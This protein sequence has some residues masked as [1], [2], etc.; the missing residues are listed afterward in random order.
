MAVLW[1]VRDLIPTPS[2][3]CYYLTHSCGWESVPAAL[4]LFLLWLHT[5]T[6]SAVTDALCRCTAASLMRVSCSVFSANMCYELSHVLH[7]W[8]FLAPPRSLV[9][10]TLMLTASVCRF[11]D[12]VDPTELSLHEQQQIRRDTLMDNAHFLLQTKS[13]KSTK[14]YQQRV[15]FITRFL[16]Y[17]CG[18]PGV[19]IWPL[20]YN[21]VLYLFSHLQLQGRT[22]GCFKGYL[23]AIE[24]YHNIRHWPSIYSTNLWPTL[25]RIREAYAL[26]NLKPV[27]SR[28]PLLPAQVKRIIDGC[29]TRSTQ[30]FDCWWRNGTFFSVLDESGA[31]SNEVLSLR[32]QRI[33]V[34]PNG[35]FKCFIP[36]EF[37]KTARLTDTADQMQFFVLKSGSYAH[38]V[39]RVWCLHTEQVLGDPGQDHWIFP[40]PSNDGHISYSTIRRQLIIVCEA[41]NIDPARLGLH[42]FR[43]GRA[44][45]DFNQGASVEEVRVTL[46]HAKDSTSTF[47]Y[48]PEDARPSRKRPRRS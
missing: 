8:M 21:S 14:R 41:E 7:Q 13:L 6:Q 19:D 23:N 26:A 40:S 29:M 43:S 45:T 10:A 39:L 28:V 3:Q 17:E 15:N 4:S 42:S 31:R 16:S 44:T 37:A 12:D 20:S 27:V 11:L 35:D 34:L 38:M 2:L 5:L 1:L 30:M 33:H 18:L 48:L 46:R 36:Y 32:S 25:R 9:N 24:W 47:R 22:S